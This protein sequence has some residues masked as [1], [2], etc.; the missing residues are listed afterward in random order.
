LGTLS[1][2]PRRVPKSRYTPPN[3]EVAAEIE[4]AVD[5]FRQKVEI[6]NRYKEALAK[7]A[8]RETGRAVPIAYL[9]TKLG[10][11]RKTVYRHLGR[12]MT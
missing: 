1:G 12:S 9:A 10:V 4:A 11:E 2:Y 3:D 8:D 7:L 6:D 5:L